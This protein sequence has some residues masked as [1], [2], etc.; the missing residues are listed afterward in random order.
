MD[1]PYSASLEDIAAFLE[2]SEK[3][4]VLRRLD[5]GH[6]DSNGI[7]LPDVKRGLFVD[8]ET[9]GLNAA[10]DDVIE[11]GIVE[12]LFDREGAIYHAREAYQGFQDS[13]KLSVEIVQITGIT[14]EMI[15]GQRLDL[16][17]IGEAIFRA[18]LIVSHKADFD[19]KFAEGIGVKGF[20]EKA[21]G[22]SMEQVPWQDGGIRGSCSL[23]FIAMEFGFFYD[24]HRAID[25]CWAGIEV[26][27]R[28]LPNSGRT[29]LGHLLE[30]ARKPTWRVWALNSHFKTKD[31]LKK[32]GY[33]WSPG[34]EP[35]MP[36]KSWY[37]DIDSETA[38]DAEVA[39]LR[40]EIYAGQNFDPRI[41]RITAYDR[42]AVRDWRQ[43]NW[44]WVVPTFSP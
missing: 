27:S 15:L 12:F 38:R 30:A 16:E 20:R 28:K 41:D 42:F 7:P 43:G 14:P 10:E 24:A 5:P 4:R 34:D 2:Q 23:K 9:S 8:V 13:D 26:L 6:W 44:N 29:A 25:D 35:G 21:W 31:P 22:C 11:L 32:R 36:M 40:A 17:K 18:D 3:Y 37:R 33:R 19:R 1:N 39:W